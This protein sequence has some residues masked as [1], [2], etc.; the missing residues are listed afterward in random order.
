MPNIDYAQVVDYLIPMIA[1]GDPPPDKS[2]NE[3][4]LV[5]HTNALHHISEESILAELVYA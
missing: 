5:A 3:L 1:L 2:D 4:E